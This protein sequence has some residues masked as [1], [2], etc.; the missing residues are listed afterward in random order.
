MTRIGPVVVAIL[1][2]FL[3]INTMIWQGCGGAPLHWDS[4]IHLS[5]SLNANRVGEAGNPSLIKELLNISWYYP[6]FVSYVSA[7]LYMLFG[8]SEFVA[9]QVMS[10]FLVLLVASTYGLGRRL[11][12]REAGLLSALLV[13]CLPIVVQ[14]SRM[15]ML[16]LPLAALVTFSMYLLVRTSSFERTIPAV[17][18]G[19]GMGFGLL[20]KWIFPLFI[21]APFV[22]AF[23]IGMVRPGNRG[24]RIR[25]ALISLFIAS[26]LAAPWYLMHAI[27]IITSRADELNRNSESLLHS[28]YYYSSTLPDQMGWLLCAITLVG[29]GA[30]FFC[31]MPGALYFGIW[32]LGGYVLLSLVGFKQPRFSISLLPPLIL[33]ASAGLLETV[34]LNI[35]ANKRQKTI[36]TLLVVLPLVQFLF[37]SYTPA[38]SQFAV[39]LS[40]IDVP[41]LGPERSDWQ[42]L[43]ILAT[44][45]RDAEKRGATFPVLRVIPDHEN[46]NSSIFEYL[47]KRSRTSC[48]V[49]GLSGYPLFTD[50]VILKSR[51]VGLDSPDHGRLR[52]TGEILADTDEN[53]MYDLLE[54]FPLPDASE[55]TLFRVEPKSVT[56]LS[57][58]SILK[59]VETETKRFV[60]NYLRP[61]DGYRLSV[62]PYSN[63]ATQRGHFRRIRVVADRAE[64]GDFRFNSLGLRVHSVQVSMIDVR[65][66]PSALVRD[67]TLR[68]LSIGGL[69][70]E[71]FGL[72]AEDL[73]NYI[74]ASSNGDLT[75]DSFSIDQGHVALRGKS[76]NIGKEFAARVR[77]ENLGLTNIGFEV[78]YAKAGFLPIP[79]VLANM[80]LSPFN[81][82]LSGLSEIREVRID[83]MTLED[84]HL[85]IGRTRR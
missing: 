20:T 74:E 82:L 62:E 9:L 81:P 4:A 41:A 48:L 43:N 29:V 53:S 22:M 55:A 8:E 84:N 61:I 78:V 40:A 6:P 23:V 46:F 14:Y 13:S 47:A 56:V 25:N 36:I 72:D 35:V 31:K 85:F 77:L 69:H 30:F 52:L 18:L 42:H 19:L 83:S 60:A 64:L 59:R 17:L 39:Y 1:C 27:Q 33:M 11:L 75:I 44:I 21:A 57:G 10:A 49:R 32:F 65:I 79:P 67:S 50:Y 28:I 26:V 38:H 7:P 34:R 2:L 71:R 73:R 68:M 3:V 16:D 54:T 5:E 66:D 76:E 45:R 15:F 80:M 12:S 63:A 51:D 70:V 24:R 37:M 58:K